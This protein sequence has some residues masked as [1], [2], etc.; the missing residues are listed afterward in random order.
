ML[1]NNRNFA[2]IDLLTTN[3]SLDLIDFSPP[4][5]ILLLNYIF[6]TISIAKKNIRIFIQTFEVIFLV[7]WTEESRNNMHWKYTKMYCKKVTICT[8]R[9]WNCMDLSWRTHMCECEYA[10]KVKNINGQYKI[11][12]NNL[13][14]NV[15]RAANENPYNVI[16]R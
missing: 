1:K 12:S 9:I 3:L 7:Q 4:L 2:K 13:R 15:K 14:E 11:S 5:F 6:Q 8:V 10:W 16:C